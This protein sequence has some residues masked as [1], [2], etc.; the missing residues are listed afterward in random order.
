MIDC[1]YNN[2]VGKIVYQNNKVDGHF[3]GVYTRA[4][5]E[6]IIKNNDIK[7]TTHNAIAVHN[8]NDVVFIGS[9][10]VENN[11]M[12]NTSSRGVRFGNFRDSI[13]RFNNNSFTNINA[14][15]YIAVSNLYNCYVKLENNTYDQTVVDKSTYDEG[16]TDY[17]TSGTLQISKSA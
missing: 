5:K 15:D 2:L 3:Q 1:M 13:L 12:E 6:V 17:F 10:L 11:V 7:N 8:G 16:T 9:V 4:A 14:T